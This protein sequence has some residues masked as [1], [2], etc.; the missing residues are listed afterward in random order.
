MRPTAWNQ[1]PAH[2]Q[3]EVLPIRSKQS[4]FYQTCKLSAACVAC[5]YAARESHLLQGLLPAKYLLAL[6]LLLWAASIATGIQAINVMYTWQATRSAKAMQEKLAAAQRKFMGLPPATPKP[7]PPLQRKPHIPAAASMQAALTPISPPQRFTPPPYS[8]ALP[9]AGAALA[10]EYT[11]PGATPVS[12]P[13]PSPHSV[14][15]SGA[16]ATPEQMKAY[17]DSFTPEA[18]PAAVAAAAAGTPPSVSP[19]ISG[20]GLAGPDMALAAAMPV[21]VEVPRYRPSWLPRAKAAGHQVAPDLLTAS[22]DEEV[23]DF[24]WSVLRARRDWMEVW[25]ERLREWFSGKVLR[26]LVGVVQSADADANKVLAKY[27][28]PARLPPL[29]NLISGAENGGPA[30][31][32]TSAGHLGPGHQRDVEAVLRHAQQYGQALGGTANPAQAEDALQLVTALRRY[33]QVLLLL[34][35]RRPHE[36]LPPAPSGYIWRRVQMLAEGSCMPAYT[37]NGGGPWAG[38]SWSPDLPNDSMLMLYLFAAFIDAP[39]WHFD[40]SSAGDGSAVGGIEGSGTVG[41]AGATRGMPLFL[42]AIKPRPPPQHS[43]VLAYRPE[44]LG[45]GV[46]AILALHPA[47]GGG[48]AGAIAAPGGG[49]MFC[50]VAEGRLLALTGYN[51]M[52]HAVLSFLLYH[53][54]KYNGALGLHYIQDDALGLAPVIEPPYPGSTAARPQSV[55]GSWFP[56]HHS[57]RE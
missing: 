11:P 3:P 6:Y 30:G 4:A 39:G 24:L 47:A 54:A 27:G 16:V 46:D 2:H 57:K 48:E 43:A 34:R 56:P 37:W 5:A 22:T 7:Q 8:Q 15:S 20:G 42:G 12:M 51:A 10:G 49:T 33:E 52:F 13:R 9:S 40:S 23:D 35:G 28:H 36:L 29:A 41:G 44:K 14:Y 31:G 18:S 19:Y 21:G 25:T 26:P 55:F 17:L 53:K 1:S 32:G 38:R 45:K 50:F